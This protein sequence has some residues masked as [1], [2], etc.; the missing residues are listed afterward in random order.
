MD[1]MLITAMGIAWRVRPQLLDAHDP[2]RSQRG[3]RRGNPSD[4]HGPDA[5]AQV[6]LRG[7]WRVHGRQEGLCSLARFLL[8]RKPPLRGPAD[9][10]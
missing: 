5:S 4:G 9:A 8:G 6:A 3:T 2:K 1:L 10:G 7:A